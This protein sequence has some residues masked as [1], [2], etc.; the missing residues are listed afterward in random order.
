MSQEHAK[1]TSTSAAQMQSSCKILMQGPVRENLVESVRLRCTRT[2]Q[3]KRNTHY[4]KLHLAQP[5]GSPSKSHFEQ[6]RAKC[7]STFHKSHFVPEFASKMPQSKSGDYSLWEP[8]QSKCTRT[9]HKKHFVPEFT[10]KMPQTKAW[11]TLL[12]SHYITVISS[13]NSMKSPVIN[14][15]KSTCIPWNP[16]EQINPT[17]SHNKKKL[18]YFVWSPQ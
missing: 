8:A 1:R 6:I 12:K 10:R 11:T 16:L 5:Q 17:E 2:R 13:L 14:P 3:N 4:N 18:L 9:L 15:I 7:I